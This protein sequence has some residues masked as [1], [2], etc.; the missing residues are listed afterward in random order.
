M[1]CVTALG[2]P[3]SLQHRL[4][5]LQTALF[6]EHG[7]PGARALPALIPLSWARYCD[8]PGGG[9]PRS[10]TDPRR[11]IP[12]YPERLPVLTPQRDLVHGNALYLEYAPAE[13]LNSLAEAAEAARS[14]TPQRDREAGG[15]D[16]SRWEAAPGFGVGALLAL[17]PPEVLRRASE[18]LPAPPS[19][20][21]RQAWWWVV[22][23]E[24]LSDEEFSG[25]LETP[26]WHALRYEVLA[27]RRIAKARD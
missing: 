17:G 25:K 18:L 5:E 14:N 23:L 8:P 1:I 2:L 10:T 22:A 27:E 26:W 6:R 19:Q 9:S 12:A 21:L 7:L 16:A 13:A 24:S 3:G 4:D 20:P 11:L 15:T